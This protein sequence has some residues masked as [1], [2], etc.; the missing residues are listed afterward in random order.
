MNLRILTPTQLKR[1]AALAKTSYDSLRHVASGR[2]GASAEMAI[3]IER[4][5]KRMRLDVRREELN[6]GCRGCEFAKKC[7]GD[8]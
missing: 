3:R 8:A 6:S 7:R 1:L 4:A 2:R 5:A